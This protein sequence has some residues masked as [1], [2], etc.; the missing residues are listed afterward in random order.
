MKSKW[1]PNLRQQAQILKK[2]IAMDKINQG[3]EVLLIDG[4]GDIHKINEKPVILLN[5]NSII[6]Y[7]DDDRFDIGYIQDGFLYCCKPIMITEHNLS[8]ITLGT[9]LKGGVR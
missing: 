8:Y 3:Y 1:I 6:C 5:W 2:K 7:L 4:Y 9:E